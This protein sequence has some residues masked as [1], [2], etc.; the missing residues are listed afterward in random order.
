MERL[1]PVSV[2]SKVNYLCNYF[3]NCWAAVAVG[4]VFF[5]ASDK[6]RAKSDGNPLNRGRQISY[7]RLFPRRE[8]GMQHD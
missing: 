1:D 6:R 2:L 5:K 8:R 7:L 4:V 3:E